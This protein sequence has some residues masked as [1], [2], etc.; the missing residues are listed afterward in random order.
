MTTLE[1]ILLALTAGSYVLHAI[2]PR[3]KTKI[4]DYVADGIDVVLP[5]V[6]AKGEAKSPAV[7]D[8]R[9]K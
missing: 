5:A 8:H 3:T 9:T 7:R 6:K 2:A 4:D 1:I